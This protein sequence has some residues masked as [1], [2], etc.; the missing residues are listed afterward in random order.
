MN[1]IE[2]D[3]YLQQNADLLIKQAS[4]IP[5]IGLFNGKMGIA[6]FLHRYAKYSKQRKYKLYAKELI[7]EIV[8]ELSVT[9]PVGIE[10]GACG[11]RL[12]FEYLAKNNYISLKSNDTFDE[13]NDF[14]EQSKP[15]DIDERTFFSQGLYWVLL[16]KKSLPNE[17]FERLLN[18]LYLNIEKI[19]TKRILLFPQLIQSLLYIV[20]ECLR[21]EVYLEKVEYIFNKLSILIKN[22]L[23]V[24]DFDGSV[25]M[26]FL[27]YQKILQLKNFKI[28]NNT[29]S[30]KSPAFS[31]VLF[32]SKCRIF[33][34]A[35]AC[36]SFENKLLQIINDKNLIDELFS[37]VNIHNL[38]LNN[39]LT[40]LG[41]ALL[42]HFDK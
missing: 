20:W 26:M 25:Y 34:N 35:E 11:I 15:D 18:Y 41:W 9:M 5:D 36:E 27:L 1:R 33:Y 14:V 21:D 31:D 40:G 4:F 19:S 13:L 32:I 30:E 10:D 7:N 3:R 2:I 28:E 6:L 37:L 22:K 24:E 12:G 39:C 29:V 8:E 23:F 42:D 16:K 38:S 17:K